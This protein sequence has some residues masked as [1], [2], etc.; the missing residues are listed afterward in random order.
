MSISPREFFLF[1]IILLRRISV[2]LSYRGE[3]FYRLSNVT[4]K[5]VKLVDEI[6]DSMIYN[7][8]IYYM[9]HHV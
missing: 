9:I 1:I 2:M 4:M 7:L 6:F 5:L 3:A 8:Y